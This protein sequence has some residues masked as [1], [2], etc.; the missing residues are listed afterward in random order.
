[1]RFFLTCTLF[2]VLFLTNQCTI[3]KR[4]HRPGW[5]VDFKGKTPSYQ[6]KTT[7][8]ESINSPSISAET[9]SNILEVN[10]LAT[11]RDSV[12]K[13]EISDVYFLH[14][15]KDSVKTDNKLKLIVAENIHEKETMSNSTLSSESKT[16]QKKGKTNKSLMWNRLEK[17]I[18]IIAFFLLLS[19]VL[20]SLYLFME[21]T[22][23]LLLYI[24][25][26]ILFYLIIAGSPIFLIILL[27]IP[28]EEFLSNQRIK[29]EK[30]I[31]AIELEKQNQESIQQH[32][33]ESKE[34][35]NQTA[36]SRKKDQ[37][38]TKI[39]TLIAAAIATVLIL[40]YFILSR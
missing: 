36:H 15:C 35:V 13:I 30:R 9:K 28:T 11:N 34:T 17:L 19:I 16:L 29:K 18:V 22:T 6:V 20:I 1:M 3:Q 2:L 14:L 38:A 32:S 33:T 21:T 12:S 40:F 7:E 24:A 37:D 27:L 8:K 39:K 4:V 5:Y 23:M 10:Q 31:R 25:S 26:I